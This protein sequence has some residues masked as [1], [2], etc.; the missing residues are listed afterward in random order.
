LPG[1]A[2]KHEVIDAGLPHR[3]RKPLP[4]FLGKHST[5]PSC[6]SSGRVVGMPGSRAAGNVPRLMKAMQPARL[7]ANAHSLCA[8]TLEADGGA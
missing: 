3:R 5:T 4:S 1:V 2:V 7:G 6:Q 8:L